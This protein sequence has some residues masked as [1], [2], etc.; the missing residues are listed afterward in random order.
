MGSRKLDMRTPPRSRDKTIERFYEAAFSP[1]LALYRQIS[2]CGWR[3]LHNN[4]QWGTPVN[5]EKGNR[6]NKVKT[7]SEVEV[8][9]TPNG[10]TIKVALANI[11]E[12]SLHLAITGKNVIIRGERIIT[13]KTIASSRLSTPHMPQFQHQI[14]LPAAVRPGGFRAQLIGD[15]IQIDFA[16]RKE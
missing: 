15:T 3:M 7:N 11:K 13:G 2:L 4:D 1:S 12:E 8:Y 16:R 5:P 10:M 14:R 6:P 9:E